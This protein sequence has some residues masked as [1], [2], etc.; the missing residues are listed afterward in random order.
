[1]IVSLAAR[2]FMLIGLVLLLVAS[3]ELA[4]GLMLR[5][6]RLDE[7][8]R[9]TEALARIAELDVDRILEG[10]RQTLATL[11]KL[12][13]DHGWDQRA[14]AV[15]EATASSDFEY[16]HI[17]GVD[18]N[19]VIR[20]SSSGASPF[21]GHPMPVMDLFN[22]IVATGGFSVG[23]YGV[24]QLSGNEVIRV[25]YPVVNAAGTVIGAIYAGI[26]LSW[27][28]TA[29]TQW[30]LGTAA[31]IQIA[32][33]A[34]IIIAQYPDPQRIGHPIG[35]DLKTLLVA[36]GGGT[37]EV[38]G[39][40]GTIRLYGY[41]PVASGPSSDV[42]VFVGR[43]KSPISAAIDR[44]IWLNAT[45]I[46]IGL[47]LAGAFVWTYLHRVLTRPFQNLQIVIGRWRDG[48][49][50]ARAS[51]TS[52]IP[53]F[54]RLSSAF[55]N[56]ANVVSAQITERDI[57]QLK[58]A[59]DLER[60]RFIFE[61][62]SDGMFVTD[63]KTGSFTDVNDAGCAMFGF[64]RDELLGRTIG[65]LSSGVA[66]YTQADALARLK[67]D[68]S[69][70]FEW[71]CKAKDDRLFWAEIS[72]RTV[73]LGDRSVGLAVVRDVTER[74][75]LHDEIT[76]QAHFD[77]LT[78]LPNRRNF[79][80]VFEQEVARSARYNRSLC[81]AMGDIDLFK[82]VNDTYG[83]D[84]GDVVLREVAE[85][86]RNRL[87]N[88]DYIARWG[89]EEF[90]ILFPETNLDAAMELLNR[91]RA[92]IAKHVVAKIGHAVT[93][94]FGVSEFASADTPG[95]VVKRVDQALYRSKHTGRNKVTG[96]PRG[97]EPAAIPRQSRT[98]S[99]DAIAAFDEG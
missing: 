8:R 59:A 19:G 70:P 55:D 48:D 51:A 81:V 7:A 92:T 52:G 26:N 96:L 77:V 66:P 50:S 27:L 30:Q 12:P 69:S 68:Q 73:L 88:S 60:F 1:M 23:S 49:W 84:A 90:I 24:G 42:A 44:S 71:H 56:M 94:S 33:S 46:A 80:D 74:R 76:H 25:G 82:E 2:I 36:P 57:I 43:D 3:G 86:M 62:A 64:L 38:K 16:D 63:A 97:G 41:E 9:D 75:R 37:V 11:A 79:E 18:Y 17:A 32:D 85:L 28:N 78:G 87:R 22:R 35:D 47:S 99:I 39:T 67:T 45:V 65:A 6:E 95:D 83:H 5:Q 72:L 54:D 61:A 20:C 40:D 34:G 53:E 98:A 93:L 13:A 89:G 10:A 91:L 31:S 58:R 15:I 21:L 4:N 14:C 29:A